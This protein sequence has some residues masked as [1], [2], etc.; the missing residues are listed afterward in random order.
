MV[1]KM[2]KY[3][4]CLFLFVLCVNSN[5]A[6]QRH[7]TTVNGEYVCTYLDEKEINALNKIK[8]RKNSNYSNNNN[9]YSSSYKAKSNSSF[10]NSADK[11]NNV[12]SVVFIELISFI[13]LISFIAGYI[14]FIIF[15]IKE[16]YRV[17]SGVD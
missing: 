7:C 14:W 17:F 13:V 11:K 2:F 10:S 4:L 5:A 6:I 9:S 12:R 1:I 15:A 3:V 16:I 8:K